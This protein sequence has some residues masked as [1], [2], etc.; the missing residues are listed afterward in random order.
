[1][2]KLAG[3]KGQD[4]NDEQFSWP[5]SEKKE[6]E[7]QG[8][9]EKRKQREQSSDRAEEEGEVGGQEKENA[10]ESV[11]EESSFS[12]VTYSIGTGTL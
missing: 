8:S 6:T 4:S 3:I 9:T 11:K 7:V 10:M 1:M 2:E 5:E 12:L